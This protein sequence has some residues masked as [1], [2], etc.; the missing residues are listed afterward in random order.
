MRTSIA[1][2]AAFVLSL[3]SWI[4]ILAYLLYPISFSDGG[5]C[6]FVVV[7]A[8]SISLTLA[9]SLSLWADD[10]SG[11]KIRLLLSWEAFPVL[12]ASILC[13]VWLAKNW[14]DISFWVYIELMNCLYKLIFGFGHG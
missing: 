3:P 7:V 12:F 2:F 1:Q 13:F 8:C 6:V 5:L 14:S 4:V 10:Y 11:W 9:T